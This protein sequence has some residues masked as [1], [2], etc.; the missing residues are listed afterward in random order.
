MALKNGVLKCS[1]RQFINANLDLKCSATPHCFHES[2]RELET[3]IPAQIEIEKNDKRPELFWLGLAAMNRARE[4]HVG[5]ASSSGASLTNRKTGESGGLDN[6][7][8]DTADAVMDEELGGHDCGG[9]CPTGNW[10]DEVFNDA[11]LFDE[12][13]DLI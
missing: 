12:H 9:D 7:K 3:F 13:E 4:R 2:D 1:H 11:S 5:K 10:L 8:R 6:G